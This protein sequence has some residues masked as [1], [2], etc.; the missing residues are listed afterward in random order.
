MCTSIG[1]GDKA[2]AD[3]SILFARNE[4]CIRANWNKAMR[5]RA[6]P[7]YLA[8]P[9]RVVDG[10]WTLANGLRVD[11]PKTHF[12]YTGMPDAAGMRER[13][14]VTGSDFFFEERG[15]NSANFG[16][17]ATNSMTSNK[18][19][20]AVDPFVHEGLAECILPTLLLSQCAS[21][22]DALK[23]LAHDIAQHGASEANGFYLS[24]PTACWYVE[25]GSGHHW[26]AVRVLDDHY[27]VVANGMRIHDVDLD[28]SENVRCSD[29]LFEFTQTHLL[30]EA[31]R[32]RFDFARAFDAPMS[33]YNTDRIWLAQHLLT[34]SLEQEPGNHAYPMFLK[35][36]AP[37]AP[38]TV[39]HLLRATYAGTI[40]EKEG[41]RPIGFFRTGESHIITL[42]PAA[43]DLLKG[44]IWQAV[45]SPLCAPYIPFFASGSQVPHEYAGGDD[46]YDPHSA[47]WAF[48][49]LHVLALA[50]EHGAEA[51]QATKW[52]AFEQHG[53]AEVSALDTTLARLAA[54]GTAALQAFVNRYSAGIARDAVA[55][56]FQDRDQLMTGLTYEDGL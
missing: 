20:Q 14:N 12:S 6:L 33:R 37:I 40:L 46:T 1:V 4:D 18:A 36:D 52:H 41:K 39:M 8:E 21:A 32:A 22:E 9:H 28:D 38:Q 51:A 10:K 50:A 11:I 5:Y 13:G 43:P 7:E 2:T 53:L 35:P 34:P 47:Y 3:G 42:D 27:I 17:S 26:I 30:P 25:I 24:D 23:R 44:M 15:V 56:A 29:G 54:E 19:A 55:Q 45:S 48:R 16:I 31:D 49:G